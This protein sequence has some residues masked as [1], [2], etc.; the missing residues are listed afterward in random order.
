MADFATLRRMMVDGQV[1]TADVT[2]RPLISA[3]LDLPR[4]LFAPGEE[5][6]AYL[7]VD[8]PLGGN[9]KLLKPMV[10]AKMVQAL[11]LDPAD[12]VLDV[13]C[14]TGYAAA[15]MGRLAGEVVGL[16]QDAALVSRAKKAISACGASNVRV[17]EGN[18]VEGHRQNAPYQAILIE[19]CIE[20]EPVA[21]TAQL[22]DGGR[23]VCIIGAG[24]ASKAVIYR[25]DGSEISERQLFDATAAVLP[26]F[27]KPKT[28]VF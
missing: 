7:D 20:I 9:R 19:G 15:L 21:L 24:P 13:G 14:G 12:K 22:A 23:M 2:D 4:E 16:E 25:R 17:V 1:R 11:D 3:M 28:F 6:L 26:G 18:L 5:K 27:V 8:L 10:L